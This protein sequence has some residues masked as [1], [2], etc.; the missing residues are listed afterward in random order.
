MRMI[1]NNFWLKLLALLIGLIVWFHVVTEKN[2]SYEVTLPVVDVDLRDDLTL[3]TMPPDSLYIQVSAKGK[4]LV[5]SAWRENG[6]RINISKMPAG[7]HSLILSPEIVQLDTPRKNV[8]VEEVLAP[9]QWEIE[10]EPKETVELP[11]TPT[12]IATAED[13]FAVSR[14]IEATPERATLTG[15]GSVVRQYSS[16]LT[17]S[18]E[19]TGLRSSVTVR[20]RIAV[21][22]LLGMRVEPDSVT[23]RIDVVPVKTR[24]YDNLAIAVYNAPPDHTVRTN[25]PVVRVELTGPPEDIELLNRN[26]LAAA[27]DYRKMTREGMAAV[28]VDCP[29]AFR[30]KTV[31]EDSVRILASPNARTRN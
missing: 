20:A 17:E 7:H 29:A 27:V 14:R 4:Q 8:V 31:S 15:P 23:L 9:S 13:G 16:L 21:P 30:V 3:A 28:S 25:P 6:I 5:Q 2:Y 12:I 1:L 26:A 11:I 24:V 10:I 22:K 19:L 18:K